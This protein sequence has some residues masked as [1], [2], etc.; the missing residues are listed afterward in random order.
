[1]WATPQALTKFGDWFIQQIKTNPMIEQQIKAVEV[2]TR[3]GTKYAFGIMHPI[4]EQD[5]YC[6]NGGAPGISSNLHIFPTTKTSEVVFIN[7][8]NNE[9]D[10]ATRVAIQIS[11]KVIMPNR[12]Y[13][14]DPKFCENSDKLFQQVAQ[15][16]GLV[17]TVKL[18]P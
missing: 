7:N 14:T 4:H 16:A 9:K 18:K 1:M 13:Y 2:D 15:E 10:L 6:H 8:D 17:A 12:I 3:H 5:F 11:N